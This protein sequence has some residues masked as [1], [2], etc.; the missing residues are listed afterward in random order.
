MAGKYPSPETAVSNFLSEVRKSETQRKW[1]ERA[2]AGASKLRDYFE[3]ALP[4]VY[5][6]VAAFPSKK[7]KTI[8]EIVEERVT[9]I[10]ETVSEKAAEYRKSKLEKLLETIRKSE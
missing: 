10:A 9:P 6:K 2:A 5:E 3:T 7:G 4:A 1:G 8:K